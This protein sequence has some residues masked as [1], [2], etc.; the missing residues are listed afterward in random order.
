MANFLSLAKWRILLTVL[1]L[2]GLYGATKLALHRLGWEPW[3]FDSLTGSLFGAA[4]FVIAFVLN[5]TLGDFRAS[6]DMPVQLANALETIQDS[7]Q[8][9]AQAHADYDPQPLSQDLIAIAEATLDWLQAEKPQ[10][11]TAIA[12]DRLNISLAAMLLYAGAPI[13]SRAQAE[14]AKM[15]LLITQIGISRDT[16]FVGP[17]Y[18]L[19]EVFVIGAVG[20][21]L[22][23]GADNFSENLVVSC[24]LFTSFAYLLLLIRDLDNPFQYDGRTSVDADLS[25]LVAFCDRLRQA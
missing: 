4:T 12:L 18:A 6:A 2:T 16:D 1:P 9:V 22:L 17:A 7:N 13:V 20:A 8:L 14:Q 15:R 5:G 3:A 11:E 25:T 24:L 10:A 23:I 21:L 19:L